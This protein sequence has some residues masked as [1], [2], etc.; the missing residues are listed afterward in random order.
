VSEPIEIHF[1]TLNG[2]MNYVLLATVGE[3][4]AVNYRLYTG[5]THAYHWDSFVNGDRWE[6]IPRKAYEGWQLKVLHWLLPK[7]WVTQ[8]L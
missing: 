4:G 8:M 7:Y 6:E 5:G 2:R 1:S 3:N